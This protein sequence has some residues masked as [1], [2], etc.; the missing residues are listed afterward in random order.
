[1]AE[2]APTGL[3]CGSCSS[4]LKGILFTAADLDTLRVVLRL[5]AFAFCSLPWGAARD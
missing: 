4:D 1:M 3:G 2:A 5:S